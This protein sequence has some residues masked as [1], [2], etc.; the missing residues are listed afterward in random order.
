MIVDESKE[1]TIKW[2][3][4]ELCD[5]KREVRTIENSIAWLKGTAEVKDGK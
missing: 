2:L 5:L 1:T 3:E 4:A